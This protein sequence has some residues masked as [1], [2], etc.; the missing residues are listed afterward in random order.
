LEVPRHNGANYNPA[1]T[2]FHGRF[3]PIRLLATG[4]CFAVFLVSITAAAD[5]F[6]LTA[7]STTGSAQTVTAS[8]SSAVDLVRDVIKNQGAFSALNNQGLD[9]SLKYGGLN[10][11]V[12]F[13]KNAA[14][15][16]ATVAFPS[17]HFQKTFNG[18][19]SSDVEKQI[20]KFVKQ[21]GAASSSAG[22]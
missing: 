22:N 2:H 12:H 14:S 17:I 9:A 11:A 13:T 10:N 5:P 6:S 8:G 18:T 7:Q 1:L 20:E 16:S 19:S 15:T 3:G 4:A 21:N